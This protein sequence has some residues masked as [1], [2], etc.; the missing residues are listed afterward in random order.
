MCCAV[1]VK[2]FSLMWNNSTK[3]PG[4]L[5]INET[6]FFIIKGY[7]YSTEFPDEIKC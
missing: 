4:S 6:S 7:F 5:H 3:L 2:C 1:F